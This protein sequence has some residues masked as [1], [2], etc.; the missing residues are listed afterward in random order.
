MRLSGV[1]GWPCG[2]LNSSDGTLH[3]QSPKKIT[4]HSLRLDFEIPSKFAD[5][6]Q[7]KQMKRMEEGTFRPFIGWAV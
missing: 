7:R 4:S 1:D 2:D 3:G 5:S 6:N